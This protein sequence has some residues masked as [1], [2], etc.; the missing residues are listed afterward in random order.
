MKSLFYLNKFL[1]KY[2]VLLSLGFS[3]VFIAN[4]FALYPAEFVRKAFDNILNA[5]Q[6]DNINNAIYI[7]IIKYSLLIVVFAM[8]KGVFMYFMRQT[9]IVVSRK[10][11]YDLK[12]EVYIKY[13][14]LSKSFYQKNNTGDLMNKITE[15]IGRIRMYTGPGLMYTVN[16]ATLFTLVITR[17]LMINL[18]LTLYVLIPLPILA[19]S[20]YY[21]SSKINIKSEDVQKELSNLTTKAQEAFSGIK[22]VKIFTN[23]ENS[24]KT[25]KRNC[26][27]YTKKQLELAKTEAFFFPLVII[28]IGISTIL[29]IYIGG[30]ESF[31]G[32]I[33]S[34]NIAEF[35]IYINMLAW[36]IASIGWVTS[37]VQRAA[38]SQK[39]INE[40]LETPEEILN[41]V[42]KET[43]I[44]GDILFD[45]VSFIYKNTGIKALNNINITI[46]EKSSFGIFG[47]TGS[48]KSTLVDLICRVYDSSSGEI[49]FNK[50]EIKDLNLNSLREAIG[51]VPQ[52]GYL[53]SGTVEENIIFGSEKRIKSEITD[54]AKKA[55]IIEEISRLPNKFDTMIGERG[56]Q[57]SGGQKQRLAIA[58][59]LY[60][61]PEIFIF[62]DCLSAVDANKEKN[63]L[64][65]L[66]KE[67]QNKTVILVSHRISTLSDC[68]YIIV[69][70]KGNI[71]EGGTHKELLIKKGLYY[72]I[73]LQQ[74]NHPIYNN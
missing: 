62:D 65:S 15:D 30:L 63:I 53:F 49:R 39:R 50:T 34:G 22:L 56:V 9:I 1:W 43:K 3:F 45:N 48:G 44:E 2:R 60:K 14:D 21:V 11:E 7:L 64:Q 37:L 29:T 74:Q 54:A 68:D 25:F 19:I 12:N 23:E 40:L 58:R 24:L 31:K 57:I 72:K 51:Y 52:D 47:K 42:E 36:P 71:I 73:Y 61:K 32:N 20:V 67:T 55:D 28:M 16:I 6:K 13:Q 27:V 66:K 17:M 8:L 26:K 41:T 59:T 5:I 18:T 10:I 33:T 69:L 46:K 35:I 4:I 38:A 70:E